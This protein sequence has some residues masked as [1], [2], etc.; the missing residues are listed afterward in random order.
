MDK[1]GYLLATSV[2]YL[3]VLAVARARK[4]DLATAA[5]EAQCATMG[6]VGFLGIPMLTLLLGSAAIG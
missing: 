4:Q 2:L 3:V 1:F 5:V 6:N